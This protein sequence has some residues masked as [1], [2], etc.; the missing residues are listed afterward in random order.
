MYK[1]FFPGLEFGWCY[2]FVLMCI[3]AFAAYQDLRFAIIPKWLTL[4]L[5]G[6][7]L[8]A[9]LLRTGWLG[10]DGTKLWLFESGSPFLGSLDGLVFSITGVLVGFAILFLMWIIGTCGGG[11]VKLFAGLGAWTGPIHIIF[12][13]AASMFVATV[14]V[15]GKMFLGQL[16][17]AQMR[18]NMERGRRQKAGAPV[19]IPRNRLTYS[20]PVAIATLVVMLWFLRSEL[21][22]VPQPPSNQDGGDTQ[23]RILDTR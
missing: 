2:L 21:H 1:P 11:D 15:I 13:L 5:L 19:A 8:V 9:N 16:T 7:G 10:Y 23:T 12:V 17:P 22:L 20:L 14:L 3:L 4:P 6:I 18:K